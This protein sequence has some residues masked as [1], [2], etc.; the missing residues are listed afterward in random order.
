MNN[1]ETDSATYRRVLNTSALLGLKS[2]SNRYTFQTQ[3][4][5][6]GLTETNTHTHTHTHT[7]K[8]R[9]N[10][11]IWIRNQAGRYTHSCS[12]QPHAQNPLEQFSQL[13]IF[14]T[15]P[16]FIFLIFFSF[17]ES[18]QSFHA[19]QYSSVLLQCFTISHFS[20][21]NTSHLGNRCL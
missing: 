12:F 8:I 4:C 13:F 20:K 16:Y 11:R 2:C 17:P 7:H 3:C 9:G 19:S 14:T 5:Y 6:M 15:T 18:T 10:G 21:I 1:D